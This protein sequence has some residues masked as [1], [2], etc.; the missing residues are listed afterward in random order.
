MN[1]FISDANSKQA[2]FWGV[3]HDAVFTVC[4][5][6]F[7]FITG[8][9]LNRILE[10]R[11][12]WKRLDDLKIYFFT[13]I[14]SLPKS[15]SRLIAEYQEL[16]NH[17]RNPKA[18]D[19]GLPESHQLYLDNVGKLS[20]SDIFKALVGKRKKADVEITSMYFNLFDTF[21]YLK[22]QNERVRTN[23]ASWRT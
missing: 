10:N 22:Y 2:L 15:L 8:I 3:S 17:V 4:I 18:Y 5:T 20:H 12:E 1:F 16:A 23:F 6:L 21:D 19:Y 7:V 11:K 9:I 14:A 13:L